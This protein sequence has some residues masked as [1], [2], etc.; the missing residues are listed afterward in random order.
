ML[1]LVWE[2][3]P[4]A[5]CVWKKR[6]KNTGPCLFELHAQMRTSH[7][8]FHG[9]KRENVITCG[10]YIYTHTAQ[11]HMLE[12]SWVCDVAR[13]DKDTQIKIHCIEPVIM[14]VRCTELVILYIL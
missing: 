9:E 3:P 4:E 6:G 10:A 13:I 2:G 5:D 14:K 1:R 11:T 12:N 8:Y 7:K